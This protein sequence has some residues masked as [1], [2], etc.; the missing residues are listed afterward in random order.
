[1]NA[2]FL[3]TRGLSVRYGELIALAPI[4]LRVTSGEITAI[5]GPS[6][7]GKTS[8]LCALNRLTELTPACRVEG[9]IELLGQDTRTIPATRLRRRIGKIFQRPNPFPMS[10]RANFALPLREHGIGDKQEQAARMERVLR[11]VGLWDE[12]ADR[13][14]S[15][16]L[17]LSGGQQQRLCI[18]RA[19]VLEPEALLLDE[20]CSA[21]DPMA[22]ALVEELLLDLRGT[23]TQII[24]THNLAQA[25]RIADQV[26]VF[27]NEGK[28]GFLLE[29]GPVAQIFSQA[30]DPRTLA[31]TSGM[32]G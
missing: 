21:L 17:A 28:G 10:I 1:M 12:V 18:A 16:A 23:Y 30:V 9:T 14:E 7:C 4:D 11:R 19:L 25:K 5:I 2:P 32:R 15:S 13:L 26:A 8:F 24:V 29:Y 3:Q 6:G 20:P 22:M 27:W 31:Y